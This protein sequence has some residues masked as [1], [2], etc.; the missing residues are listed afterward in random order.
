MVPVT[1]FH[2]G[3][4]D[5]ATGRDEDNRILTS[6]LIGAIPLWQSHVT[7]SIGHVAWY[8]KDLG[9]PKKVFEVWF[10]KTIQK[11]VNLFQKF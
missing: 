7:L 11:I 8:Q 9:H 4:F 1:Y 2:L 6:K 10:R 3:F 5:P